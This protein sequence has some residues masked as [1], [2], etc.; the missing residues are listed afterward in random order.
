M[1]TAVGATV[2]SVWPRAR[3]R[4]LVRDEVPWRT[5]KTSKTSDATT[6]HATAWLNAAFRSIRGVKTRN[7]RVSP[8]NLLLLLATFFGSIC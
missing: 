8:A 2:P 7:E 5:E 3:S 1:Q 6:E 4:C